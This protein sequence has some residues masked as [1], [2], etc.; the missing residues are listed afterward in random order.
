MFSSLSMT[1][2]SAQSDQ[3]QNMIDFSQLSPPW[4]LMGVVFMLSAL[5]LVDQG[6]TLI[7]YTDASAKD[8]DLVSQLTIDANAKWVT[9]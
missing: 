5:A 4:M 8:P 2:V 1:P 3:H 6:S 7:V 9:T